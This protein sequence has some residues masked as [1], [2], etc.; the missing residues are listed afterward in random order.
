MIKD[1]YFASMGVRYEGQQERVGDYS[2]DLFTDRW[3]G[4]SFLRR[5]FESL[6]QA[7]DRI[8]APYSRAI[9][10]KP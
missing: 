2:L 7:R 5:P 6:E 1:P 10:P 3:T 8:R 4:S 9:K